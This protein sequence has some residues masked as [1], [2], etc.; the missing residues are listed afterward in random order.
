MLFPH[1]KILSLDL[2]LCNSFTITNEGQTTSLKPIRH[3][4]LFKNEHKLQKG[5]HIGL[6]LQK[7][8]LLIDL[9]QYIMF[10]YEVIKLTKMEL[11]SHQYL[12]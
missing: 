6:E 2:L 9:K 5:V 1:I 7:L 11:I 3:F 4:Y 12:Y 8:N 10:K